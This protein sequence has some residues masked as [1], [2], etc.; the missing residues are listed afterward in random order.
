MLVK[1]AQEK[2]AWRVEKAHSLER[3]SSE[4]RA[5]KGV[6]YRH[7]PNSC[8]SEQSPEEADL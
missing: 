1:G 4:T 7:H 3:P 5:G 2:A 6:V 8:L